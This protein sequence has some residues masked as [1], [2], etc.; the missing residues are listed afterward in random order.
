LPEGCFSAHEADAADEVEITNP[1]HPLFGRRFRVYKRFCRPGKE[2]TVQV[3]FT[4]EIL[5][6]IPTS[7]LRVPN[8]PLTKLTMESVDDLVTAFRA[9]AACP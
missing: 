7:A 6:R 8:E 3:F 2:P 5:L 1:T 9:V 4:D